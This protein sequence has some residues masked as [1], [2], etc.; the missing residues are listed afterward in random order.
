MAINF[1]YDAGKKI[2]R[3]SV[4]GQVDLDEYQSVMQSI[5]SSKDHLPNVRTIWDLTAL[6]F[7]SLD[8][9]REEQIVYIHKTVPERSGATVAYVVA[10]ELG[11]GMMRMLEAL[12]GDGAR[13]RVFY[14]Y[15]EAEDWLLKN[16]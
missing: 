9:Q 4:T 13:S 16:S 10:N 14:D 5:I 15:A 7:S 2:L 8:R 3:V 1:S 11:F 6:D 12:F